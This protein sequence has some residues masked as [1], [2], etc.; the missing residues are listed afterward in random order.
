V[1]TLPEPAYVL[2]CPCLCYPTYAVYGVHN[3]RHMSRITTYVTWCKLV[4]RS[5]TRLLYSAWCC[6]FG[7]VQWRASGPCGTDDLQVPWVL[8]RVSAGSP[9]GFLEDSRRVPRV[10][11]YAHTPSFQYD[12]VFCSR[13]MVTL[14]PH[15]PFPELHK[16]YFR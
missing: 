2:P 5:I 14:P 13:Y 15:H 4:S 7:C 8:C 9:L 1:E 16:R 11:V 10:Y 6:T 3:I 12:N